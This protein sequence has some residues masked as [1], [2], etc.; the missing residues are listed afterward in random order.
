[1]PLRKFATEKVSQGYPAKG[2]Y[3]DLNRDLLAEDVQKLV[4][5]NNDKVKRSEPRAVTKLL[6]GTACENLHPI[7]KS[8]LIKMLLKGGSL[9]KL[10]GDYGFATVDEISDETKR[11]KEI[12]LGDVTL[13]MPSLKKVPRIIQK[14]VNYGICCPAKEQ[15]DRPQL[16]RV[17]DILRATLVFE[18]KEFFLLGNAYDNNK[19]IGSQV[20]DTFNKEFGGHLVQVKNRFTELRKPILYAYVAND[21][22]GALADPKSYEIDDVIDYK[23][24]QAKLENQY[25]SK[26]LVNSIATL[27][28]VQLNGRDTFYRD[29]QLLIK[30]PSDLYP[31]GTPL[32]H[33]Y[34]ELQLANRAL[35]DSKSVHAADGSSGHD[36]YVQIR[37]VMEYCEM[38]YWNYK[39]QRL[40]ENFKFSM[41]D[42]DKFFPSPLK[43]DFQEFRPSLIAMWELYE[44]YSGNFRKS[45]ESAI[46]GSDWYKNA[47]K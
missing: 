28:N 26:N 38:L 17:V 1:M 35:Y 40:D 32:N 39:N 29:L 30:L 24:D 36:K 27:I 5:I 45:L 6:V 10:L 9:N 15:A 22:A 4:D 16:Q 3:E 41:P 19:N 31:N 18:K 47:K 21:F 43:K 20:I 33:V 25:A 42:L 11:E 37:S 13:V 14:A 2:A 8:Q 44:R 23:Q 7:I 12:S 46:D 34:V